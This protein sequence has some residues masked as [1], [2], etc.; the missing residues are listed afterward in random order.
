MPERR[1]TQITLPQT[2][3]AHRFGPAIAFF[4]V[5]TGGVASSAEAV[6]L[7]A[8][9]TGQT[10]A[11]C[12]NGFPEL[13]PYGR[14]FKLNGYTFGGGQSS[15]PPISFMTVGSFTN[16]QAAQPGGAA[17]HFGDNNNPAIDFISM[18]YGGVLLPNVGMFGQITYDNIGKQLS[19]DNTDL[20]A[21]HAYNFGGHE[22][23]LGVSV[24]NN[25]TVED[26][27]NDTPAWSFPWLSS[28]LA[29]TPEAATLIEG[30]LAQQVV[31]ITP[32]VYWDRLIYAE[33][34]VY[35]TLGSRLLYELGSN[36][37]PPSPINGVA[38]TWRLAFEPKWGPNSWEVGTFGLHAATVPGGIEGFGTDHITDVGLDTQYQYLADVNSFSVDA[39]FIAESDHFNA[40]YQ[41]GNSSHEHDHLRSIH[42]KTS[43]Y[44]DQTYGGTLG[45]F[46]IDGSGDAALYGA[47]SASNSP[48][49]SGFIGELDY[50]PFN[51]GGPSF[52]PWL[53][54]KFGLQYTY[55]TRFNGGVNNYDGV[56]DN[57][58]G[59]NTLYAF[60]WLAF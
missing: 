51:H 11:A 1:Y 52:W 48:N 47:D 10:C 5:L 49:S 29:P 32:Y 43:Y 22:T 59:A 36:P 31:G 34:G 35:R 16:T 55:Y 60:A 42:I 14:L 45:W 21:A 46:H 9:Q 15:L 37:G 20:R 57:A 2:L 56:G 12:H 44:Y 53:N 30:G 24:N 50:M 40:S 17:P 33:V 3:S 7:F 54:V 25:P 39:S 26:V 4:A 6:P 18:F 27:W 8:R 28:G 41:L 23:I 38:P 58:T 13:T 19:W